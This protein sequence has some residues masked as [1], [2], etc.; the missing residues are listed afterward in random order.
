MPP[1]CSSAWGTTMAGKRQAALP[2]AIRVRI[3]PTRNL[4]VLTDERCGCLKLSEVLRIEYQLNTWDENLSI[5][6]GEFINTNLKYVLTNCLTS[7]NRLL[8][9]SRHVL[10]GLVLCGIFIIGKLRRLLGPCQ[11]EH[12]DVQ[13]LDAGKRVGTG[14]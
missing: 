9:V 6:V 8:Y 2:M 4:A 13:A 7:I 14:R 5:L 12:A 11:G 3:N 10:C 1:E